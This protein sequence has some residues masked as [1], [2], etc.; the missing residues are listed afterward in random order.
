MPDN[1]GLLSKVQ[2]AIRTFGEPEV[3][4]EGHTDTAE[5]EEVS[6]H[7]SQERAELST[8]WRIKP[9]QKTRLLLSDTDQNVLWHPMK[10][11]WGVLLTDESM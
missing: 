7:L 5:S 11:K 4:I 2:R 8:W 6:E 1:Y 3:V 10:L 9:Y